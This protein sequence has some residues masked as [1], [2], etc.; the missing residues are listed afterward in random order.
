M[1]YVHPL[2]HIDDTV[3]LGEGTKV[4]QFAS[5]IRHAHIGRHCVIGATAIVDGATVGS[6]CKIGAGAQ[7]HP[8]TQ[9]GN[10]V[11]IG[12]GAIICNDLW[13]MCSHD[14]FNLDAL[15]NGMVCTVAIDDGAA[16]G[17][18]AIIMPGV[19]IEAGAMVAAGVV[20]DR[21]VPRGMILR[22]DGS[23]EEIPANRAVR[24]MR[25]AT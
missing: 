15:L 4:W 14:G 23:V 12:P 13:P 18:G 25:S 9:I 1:T 7:L 10:D 3:T 8:G 17:A 2:A 6:R 11:F 16:I 5:V 21:M 22:R 20:C 19:V 24:R